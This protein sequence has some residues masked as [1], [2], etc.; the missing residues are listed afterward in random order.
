[1]T[2]GK[3][4]A[5]TRWTFVSKVMSLLQNRT[6]LFYYVIFLN[7]V[8]LNSHFSV[9]N[10]KNKEGIPHLWSK[11]FTSCES[12]RYSFLLYP[13]KCPLKVPWA[14]FSQ[15]VRPRAELERIR[16]PCRVIKKNRC[17]IRH[18][19]ISDSEIRVLFIL[20]GLQ[21]I[22]PKNTRSC[23]IFQ[24]VSLK[25]G[26][27]SLAAVHAV[28][29]WRVI[30]W[31]SRSDRRLGGPWLPVCCQ[32][33]LTCSRNAGLAPA[34]SSQ[35]ARQEITITNGR[36]LFLVLDKGQAGEI[37]G[38]GERGRKNRKWRGKGRK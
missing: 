25:A 4:I 38:G 12:Y 2:T 10:I 27:S 5:L 35:R 13:Q 22:R 24:C 15:K 32:P 14:P 23:L 34:P 8:H 17:R 36:P 3:T 16:M 33:G 37:V 20:T 7:T 11:A 18:G 21:F 28:R 6:L 9:Q 1:M 29:T 19:L 30:L 26:K 31:D